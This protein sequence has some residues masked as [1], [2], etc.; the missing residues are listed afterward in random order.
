MIGLRT[1]LACGLAALALAASHTARAGDDA[2]LLDLLL[3]R[4]PADPVSAAKASSELEARGRK[5]GPNGDNGRYVEGP[6]RSGDVCIEHATASA[7]FGAMMASASVCDGKTGPLEA[8]L[9]RSFSQLRPK[10]EPA[11]PGVIKAFEAGNF[12]IVLFHGAPGFDTGPN[13][14][15]KTVSYICGLHGG[16]PQ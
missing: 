9:A 6:I 13:P 3:C 10:A 11:G 2:A 15:S 14:A 16:G 4:Q 12:S 1:H 7:A 5:L 8:Y